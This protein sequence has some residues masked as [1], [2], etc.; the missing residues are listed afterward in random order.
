[1]KDLKVTVNSGAKTIIV[2]A[3]KPAASPESVETAVPKQRGGKLN[4]DKA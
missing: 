3:G 1:M 2:G 4:V